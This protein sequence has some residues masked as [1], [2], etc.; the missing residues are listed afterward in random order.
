MS[1]VKNIKD[2]IVEITEKLH[3]DAPGANRKDIVS[4][5]QE[6]WGYTEQQTDNVLS[7]IRTVPEGSDPNTYWF[8]QLRR[9]LAVY[10]PPKDGVKVHIPHVTPK[11][12]VKDIYPS[13][14]M[15]EEM[16]KNELFKFLKT[17]LD[18]VTHAEAYFNTKSLHEDLVEAAKKTI[19]YLRK[20]P[21]QVKHF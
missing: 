18:A 5:A 19:K 12:E 16:S 11:V 20:H 4:G 14:Q 21:K 6:K 9:N 10:H 2:L 3:A 8:T 7:Y 1:K 15:L 17:N 13:D